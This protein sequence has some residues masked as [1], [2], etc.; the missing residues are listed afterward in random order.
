MFGEKCSLGADYG[1]WEWRFYFSTLSQDFA[2][3]AS[4]AVITTIGESLYYVMSCCFELQKQKSDIIFY[5]YCIEICFLL[6]LFYELF[7]H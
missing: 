3:G 2:L 7:L 5:I 4:G 1:V 6:N